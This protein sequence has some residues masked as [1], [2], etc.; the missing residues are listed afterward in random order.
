[1]IGRYAPPAGSPRTLLLLVLPEG[2]LE[3]VFENDDPAGGLQG[4]ALID[5]LPR[6]GGQAQLV[7]GV[8]AVPAAG[9]V[10]VDQFRLVQATQEVLRGAEHLRG[11]AD[12]VGRVVLIAEHVL[13]VLPHVTST[14]RAP[15]HKRW[16]PGLRVRT[17]SSDRNVGLSYPHQP[18]LTASGARIAY[19]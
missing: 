17:P 11:L 12:G 5:H 3:L 9:A 14:S 16:G 13:G 2:F 8:A 7:A 6:P 4:G 1:M 18:P 10:R 19:A 15:A